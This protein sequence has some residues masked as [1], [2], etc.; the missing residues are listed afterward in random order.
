MTDQPLIV[1][2]SVNKWF[3]SL[4]VLKDVDLTVDKGEVVVVIGPS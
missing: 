2:E 3:G 4:H 1:L